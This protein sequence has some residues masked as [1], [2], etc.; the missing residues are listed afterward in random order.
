MYVCVFLCMFEVILCYIWRFYVIFVLFRCYMNVIFFVIFLWFFCDFLGFFS[1][2]GGDLS[3]FPFFGR[4]MT[5]FGILVFV[6]S[7]KMGMRVW[8]RRQRNQ[9]GVS[10]N[11]DARRKVWRNDDARIRK[12][13]GG[14]TK[15]KGAI[16]C[17]VIFPDCA[18]NLKFCLCLWQFCDNYESDFNIYAPNMWFF[19]T[20]IVTKYFRRV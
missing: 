12:G 17:G 7:G 5:I 2:F 15:Y 14:D 18:A 10:E 11:L 1:G 19:V 13:L 3:I 4:A 9:I 16:D 6:D 20:I 8:I